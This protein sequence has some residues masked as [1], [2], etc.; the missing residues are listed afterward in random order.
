MRLAR[1]DQS[2]DLGDLSRYTRYSHL[3][4]AN[5]IGFEAPDQLKRLA[6]QRP[7]GQTYIYY[8]P[9]DA[10]REWD[11]ESGHFEAR[12][13]KHVYG[14]KLW[15]PVPELTKRDRGS[16]PGILYWTDS[17]PYRYAVN[18]THPSFSRWWTSEV[19]MWH[20]GQ[21][22][23]VGKTLGIFIDNVWDATSFPGRL[24]V[25]DADRDGAQDDVTLLRASW[26]DSMA[27][28]LA[29]LSYRLPG[30]PIL[31]NTKVS[32]YQRWGNGIYREHWIPVNGLIFNASGRWREPTVHL[33]RS[34]SDADSRR[35]ALCWCLLRNDAIPADD[36]F[37]IQRDPG[38][39][40]WIPEYD[41]DL[42]SGATAS[43][44]IRY[45]ETVGNEI[46]RQYER[47][48]VYWN[49]TTGAGRIEA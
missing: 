15:L 27:E 25:C 22:D 41:L 10:A 6:A 37:H 5:R 1:I 23:L 16:N 2:G 30:R 42:G 11:Y 19:G 21:E 13:T 49:P 12:W 17:L 20:R 33:I 32:T 26:Q 31:Q 45:L 36:A 7:A 35:N 18:V 4:L 3:V 48:S 47:G 14:K 9:T 39:V 44:W 38:G 46:R 8:S 28:A 24:S 43:N 40:D 29:V 34:K